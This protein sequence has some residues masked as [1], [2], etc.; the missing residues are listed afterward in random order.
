MVLEG[1]VALAP[2]ITPRGSVTSLRLPLGFAH[3][4]L[5]RY[6][7]GEDRQGVGL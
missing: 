7:V 1:R 6:W 3:K 5:V 4:L 2:D